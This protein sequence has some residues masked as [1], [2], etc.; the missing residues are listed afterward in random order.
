M[1]RVQKIE[2]EPVSKATRDA[3]VVIPD[4]II[5]ISH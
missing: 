3:A 2:G 5:T 1:R 4:F